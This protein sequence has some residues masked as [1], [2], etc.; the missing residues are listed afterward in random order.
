LEAFVVATDWRSLFIRNLG[1]DHTLAHVDVGVFALS[2]RTIDP[3]HTPS[4]IDSH[5]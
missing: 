3:V 2:I 1:A 5:G 4:M